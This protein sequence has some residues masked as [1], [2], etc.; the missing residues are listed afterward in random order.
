MADS[1]QTLNKRFDALPVEQMNAC[2]DLMQCILGWGCVLPKSF[3]KLSP[4]AFNLAFDAL[5]RQGM[6]GNA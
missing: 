2:N 6:A 3:S 1:I 5:M 4:E